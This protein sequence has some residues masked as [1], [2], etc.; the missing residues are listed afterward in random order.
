MLVEVYKPATGAQEAF[1][2][3][4]N[5]NKPLL[6]QRNS[7]APSRAMANA[8]SQIMQ[9]SGIKGMS[10]PQNAEESLKM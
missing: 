7:I 9:N 4:N 1:L 10:E 3:M 2:N 5:M 6:G 8:G